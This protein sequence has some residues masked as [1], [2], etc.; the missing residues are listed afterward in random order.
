[1][2][3]AF[4]GYTGAV[5]G[6][7]LAGCSATAT[8]DGYA[9]SDR[10]NVARDEYYARKAWCEQIGGSMSMRTSPL[11]PPGLTEYRSANCVRR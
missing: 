2:R 7:L 8:T 4:V 3:H 5:L 9:G 11:A 10:L 1:M 6:L